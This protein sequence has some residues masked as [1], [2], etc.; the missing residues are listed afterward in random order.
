MWQIFWEIM[1]EAWQKADQ[2][3]QGIYFMAA[4]LV[5]SVVACVVMWMVTAL[6]RLVAPIK[7]GRQS[8]SA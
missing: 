2:V 7:R 5:L 1:I 3:D 4:A 8:S 6:S